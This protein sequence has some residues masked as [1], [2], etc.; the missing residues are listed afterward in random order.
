M[1]PDEMEYFG[2]VFK[3]DIRRVRDMLVAIYDK[4][5][6]ASHMEVPLYFMFR[7]LFR[8]E[9]DKALLKKLNVRYCITIIPALKRGAELNRTFGHGHAIAKPG[10][11]YPEVY[12]ILEGEAHF[13]FQRVEG[14][15][16]VDIILIKA[17]K[18]DR[19]IVPPNTEHFTTNHSKKDLKMADIAVEYK[20]DY[21]GVINRQGAA[22]FELSDGKFVKNKNYGKI[23][24]IRELKPNNDI[25]PPDIYTMIKMPEML[26]LL[27]DPEQTLK[28]LKMKR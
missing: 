25:I 27:R 5:W 6:A 21:Q 19:V 14:K 2:R 13:L 28:A 20:S 7:H 4:K 3:A 1:K 18:G 10:M 9:K 8:S 16:A 22:Y 24:E 23:A 26:A 17:K 12:E 11:T 15:N